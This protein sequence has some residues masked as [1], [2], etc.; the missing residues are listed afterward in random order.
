MFLTGVFGYALYWFCISPKRYYEQLIIAFL[1]AVVLHGLYNFFWSPAFG[2]F[3]NKMGGVV[4]DATLGSWLAIIAIA[5]CSF[6]FFHLVDISRIPGRRLISPLGLFVVGGAV[7]YGASLIVACLFIPFEPAF[8]G[9]ARSGLSL[10]LVAWIYI[11]R[12]RGE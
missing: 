8:K 1:F 7:I 5:V 10:A 11:N 9:S 6:R 3:A 12:F 2:E 4:F